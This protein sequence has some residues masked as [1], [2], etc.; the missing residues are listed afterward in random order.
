[1]IFDL[2]NSGADP[3]KVVGLWLLGVI[4]GIGIGR[5]TKRSNR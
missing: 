1:M 3:S 5:F 4:F 2:I